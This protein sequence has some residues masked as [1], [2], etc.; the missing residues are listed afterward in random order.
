MGKV[1]QPLAFPAHCIAR[2]LVV[3]GCHFGE[4]EVGAHKTGLIP[5]VDVVWVDESGDGKVAASV[6][7]VL[8]LREGGGGTHSDLAPSHLKKIG[9]AMSGRALQS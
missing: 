2:S 8:T 5:N 1:D 9:G 6:I 7:D 4:P 3:T